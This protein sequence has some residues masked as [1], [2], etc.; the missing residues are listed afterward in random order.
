MLL[1][2]EELACTLK[3]FDQIYDS[4]LAENYLTRLVFI[5]LLVLADKEGIVDISREAI[6]R[7]TNVPIKIVNEALNKLE[8]VEQGS[9]STEQEG[10]R[11]IRL[12]EHRDWGWK[13]V[14][15]EAY[16]KMQ[17]MDAKRLYFREYRRK[18][19]AAKKALT[20]SVQPCSTVFKKVTP[21][22]VA[23]DVAVDVN[24]QP[25]SQSDCVGF[26]LFWKAWPKHFRK[27]G[28]AKCLKLW[29]RQNL[30][31]RSEQIISALEV[32]KKSEGWLKEGGQFIPMPHTFLNRGDWD[33][34]LT[35]LAHRKS[36]DDDPGLAEYNAKLK[37]T[38]EGNVK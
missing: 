36:T 2:K 35:D 22:D 1:G 37:Q 28:K 13:I 34:D 14:N 17:D 12:D 21:V 29:K 10:R 32:H 18:Q 19:R 15:Y 6:A 25:S 26:G 38:V 7:R 16:N 27:T 3:Y 23:V 20:E 24:K 33:C 11:I 30:E 8:Q 31:K 4:S 5:D 9:R